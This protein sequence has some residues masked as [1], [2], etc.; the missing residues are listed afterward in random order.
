MGAEEDHRPLIAVTDEEG[1]SGPT[2]ERLEDQLGWY[3]R[4][5]VSAQAAYKRTKVA[6]LQVATAIR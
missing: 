4:K 1:A 5:S 2:W 6:E 3:D